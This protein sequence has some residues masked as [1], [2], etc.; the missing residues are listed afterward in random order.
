MALH[1]RL[2]FVKLAR[3]DDKKYQQHEDQEQRPQVVIERMAT[4]SIHRDE[5]Y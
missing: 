1:V 5:A 4:L 3:E 2:A